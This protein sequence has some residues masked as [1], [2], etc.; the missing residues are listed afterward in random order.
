MRA[1]LAEITALKKEGVRLRVECAIPKKSETIFHYW[2][3]DNGLT[4]FF[5]RGDVKFIVITKHWH[6]GQSVGSSKC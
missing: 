2:F 3:T 5:A 4:L 6:I 1:D